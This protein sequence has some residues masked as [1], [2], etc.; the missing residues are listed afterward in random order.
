MRR[1]RQSIFTKAKI[2]S[3]PFRAERRLLGK[4][5]TICTIDAECCAIVVQRYG[6][7]MF[8][9]QTILWCGMGVVYGVYLVKGWGVFNN[10]L[11]IYVCISEVSLWLGHY[12]DA[13]TLLAQN[14]SKVNMITLANA[15]RS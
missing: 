2:F 7:A 14:R 5:F 6:G 15:G 12:C 1:G 13:R 3:R 11:Y 10:T 9:V 4:S 8:V